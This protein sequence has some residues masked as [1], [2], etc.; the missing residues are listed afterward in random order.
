MKCLISNR[1]IS[2]TNRPSSA[3]RVKKGRLDG[4]NAKILLSR[5]NT[6]SNR[7]YG[8]ALLYPQR[9]GV[10]KILG[11]WSPILFPDVDAS[12]VVDRRVHGYY[13]SSLHNDRDN[14]TALLYFG[15]RHERSGNSSCGA[16]V[17]R[18]AYKRVLAGIYRLFFIQ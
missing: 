14:H 8:V 16:R 1:E 6:I 12:H 10:Y 4:S 3:I 11:R 7:I 18:H 5:V 2:V 15:D 9:T 13:G 17:L